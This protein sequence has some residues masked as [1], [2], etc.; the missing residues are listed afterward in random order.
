MGEVKVP[1]VEF[2]PATEA[3]LEAEHQVFGAAEGELYRRYSLPWA[4]PPLEW[5]TRI[6]RHLLRHD[7]DRLFV[8]EDAGRVVAFSAGF[9]R[10]DTWFL[11][12]M[13]VVPAYQGRGIARWLLDLSWRGGE[14]E[15]RITI[16][17]AIQPVSNTIY[18]RRGLIPA[19]PILWLSGQVRAGQPPRLE[20]AAT[21][22]GPLAAIDRASY[23]FD[24]TPDHAHWG[25][26]AQGTLWLRG[27]EP[28]AYSYAGPGRIGPVAARDE[29][30]AADALRS[31]LA[32][33]DGQETVVVVPGSASALVTAALQAGL[34]FTG[35]PGLL[36][37]TT[38]VQPPR[39]VAISNYFLP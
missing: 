26:T 23:G 33:V 38:N 35:A 20:A 24:R 34:R 36:L 11:S 12:A 21:E 10:D 1:A 4:D 31:E 9:T 18:A 5:F 27:G 2:R 25:E 28:A 13:F 8:A 37:L 16:T 14:R 3:D 6:H 19:T 17:D 15:R 29:E 39:A 32:R 30:S 7:G 22:P